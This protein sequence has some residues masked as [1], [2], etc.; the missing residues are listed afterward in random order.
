MTKYFVTQ[1]FE[2]YNL[3]T[4]LKKC[5]D[6]GFVNNSSREAMRFDWIKENNGAY[7]AFVK[8]NDIICMSGCHPFEWYKNT[9]RI[10]YRSATIPGEDPF[11]GFSKYGYNGIPNR[12]LFQYQ[13]KWCQSFGIKDFILTTNS[14]SKDKHLH[15]SHIMEVKI[16]E[17]T[18]LSEYLGD[19]EL[20]G[21][22]QSLWKYNIEEYVKSIKRLKQEDY[23]IIDKLKW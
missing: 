2:K 13:I 11:K 14:K 9:Y 12:V 6:L 1:D 22:Q 23:Y 15:M 19:I 8:D 18:K 7:W 10:G 4:F 16:N 5:K 3:D 21:V 20:F 17:C